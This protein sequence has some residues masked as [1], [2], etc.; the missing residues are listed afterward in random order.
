MKDL[1]A[2]ILHLAPIMRRMPLHIVRSA[3]VNW[4]R[5]P[6]PAHPGE[7]WAKARIHAAVDAGL[8]RYDSV[9]GKAVGS[10]PL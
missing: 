3:D 2:L 1:L 10:D 4:A 7:G 8:R 5:R 6:T 9:F